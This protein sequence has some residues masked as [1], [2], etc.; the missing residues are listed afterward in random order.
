MISGKEIKVSLNKL[1]K[2]KIT[3]PEV[4][5]LIVED[6]LVLATK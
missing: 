3:D 6:T 4:D 1:L 5:G 2:R